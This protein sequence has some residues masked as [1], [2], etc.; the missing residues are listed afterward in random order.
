MS[1]GLQ[2]DRWFTKEFLRIRNLLK[3]NGIIVTK[4]DSSEEI[5]DSFKNIKLYDKKGLFLV[6]HFQ[7]Y[8]FSEQN[9]L[10]LYNYYLY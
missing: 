10:N 3:E 9:F 2:Y 6:F 1:R 5:Y 8:Q 4:I 7:Y